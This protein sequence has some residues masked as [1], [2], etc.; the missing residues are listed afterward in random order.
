MP[1][2]S[3]SSHKG[4]SR[5]IVGCRVVIEDDLDNG[6]RPELAE[7]FEVH[8]LAV[9]ELRRGALAELG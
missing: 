5:P 2:C 3:S 7:R 9:V 1:A 8:R 4:C 6:S